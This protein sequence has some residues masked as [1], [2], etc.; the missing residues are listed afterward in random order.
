MDDSFYSFKARGRSEFSA[1]AYLAAVAVTAQQV[2]DRAV[3]EIPSE[4]EGET[5]HEGLNDY[6]IEVALCDDEAVREVLAFSPNLYEVHLSDVGEAVEVAKLNPN[7]M[8]A[9]ADCLGQVAYRAFE[10][11]LW[12]AIWPIYKARFYGTTETWTAFFTDN[13]D[14]K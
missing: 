4:E 9:T 14:R 6:L 10:Q 12:D 13:D 8:K 2:L 5:F 1:S 3:E 11:D 7:K